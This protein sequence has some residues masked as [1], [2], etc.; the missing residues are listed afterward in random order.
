LNKRCS[1]KKLKLLSECYS[2][3]VLAAMGQYSRNG[4]DKMRK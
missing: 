3:M 1:N 2:N 4:V